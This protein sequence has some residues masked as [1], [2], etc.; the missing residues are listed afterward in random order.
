MV[1]EVP[2]CSPSQLIADLIDRLQAPI[3]AYTPLMITGIPGIGKTEIIKQVC[4]KLSL[5]CWPVRPIQHETV[6]YT[7]LPH[8]NGDGMAHWVPFS[9]LMPTDPTWEGVIPIDEITQLDLASQKIVAS[10]LDKE[11]VAGRR[12]PKLA[13][14]ILMGN[15][16]QDRAGSTRLLSIIES[17]CRQVELLFSLDDWAKWAMSAG[18]HQS[19]V[20][21]AHFVGAKFVEFD[22]ARTLNPLP[23]TWHNVSKE[24]QC[25]PNATASKDDPVILAAVRGWVG[26]GMAAMFMAFREHYQLLHGVVDQ[27]FSDSNANVPLADTSVQHALVGAIAS[28]MREMNGK[29][30]DQQRSNAVSFVK[31]CLPKSLQALL[32]LQCWQNKGF[33]SN[34]DVVAWAVSNK[35]LI[36]QWSRA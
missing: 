17:R 30:T 21:F 8:V 9:D 2:G 15:R 25:H 12:V 33:S 27:I 4:A 31:R 36:D 32:V 5:A 20:S 26:S 18:V 28:R 7:G 13:R 1:S 16:Q 22:P 3:D 19:V 35:A 34:P 6:E 11:G 14:F 24:L 10:V 23:R 29:L